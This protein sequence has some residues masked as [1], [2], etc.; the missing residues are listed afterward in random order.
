MIV[1][2]Y[3]QTEAIDAVYNYF[4]GNSGNPLIGMPTA[5]GKS[6]LPAIFFH[7]V[8]HTWPNQR[9]LLM[10]HVG[11]IL[12]QNINKIL[13]VWPEAPLGVYSSGLKRKDTAQNIICGSIQSMARNPQMFGH[14]DMIWIDEAHL[15]SQEENSQYLS[16]LAIMKLINPQVKIVG[17]SATLYRMG[18]GLLTDNGLFTDTCYDLTSMEGFN[19]LLNEGYLCQLIPFKTHTQLDVSDVSVQ[20]GEFVATQLQ[21]AVD[22]ADITFKA[23]QEAVH[24]G[25]DRRSW[26]IFS[27]GIN[28]AEHIAEQLS[29]FGIDCAPVHSKRDPEYN[30]KALAAFKN[31]ELQSLVSFSKI[32]TG[33]DH[34]GTDLI[35][36]LQPTLSI[37][38]HV[39]K[40]GRGMRTVYGEG[41][42]LN[43]IDGRLAAIKNGPKPDC[44][45]L[46]FARN[47]P[48]LGAV[49][50]PRIPNK[51]G[52]GDGEIPVK[53]CEMCGAYNHISAR[54][55]CN[56]GADFSFAVKIV[57]KA[58]TDELIKAA[59]SEPVPI[60][61]TLSVMTATYEKHPGKLYKPPTIKVTYFTPTKYTEYVCLEHPGMPGKMARD[62]WRQ[63][64]KVEPPA[65]IDTALGHISNLRCP[66]F[67]RVH[68]N[69][70]YP[71]VLGV[72]F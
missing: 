70:K 34:P 49:N 42:E 2:R 63:R 12:K 6:I 51:K 28:H 67:I 31:Y 32:T 11:E 8:L 26:L 60:I 38:R 33:F 68:T 35:I 44:R 15:V 64:S 57:S 66:R 61:E 40:Y 71:E 55:C 22:K 16:F 30:E 23:L 5:S 54:A 39:Q 9:F 53:I 62:W 69:K 72:E 37:P 29:A 17:M 46:D 41:H 59:A 4:M 56:C 47:V 50:D 43:S 52:K 13:E 24:A 19:K 18:Q 45:C 25:K 58:G 1:P 3:Y 14:R 21:G 48:R 20:H 36:D 10:S 27:S 7:K 65:T